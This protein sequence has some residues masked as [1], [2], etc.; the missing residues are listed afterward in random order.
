MALLS[1]L[2]QFAAPERIQKQLPAKSTHI[3]RTHTKIVFVLPTSTQFGNR[4][5]S[6]KVSFVLI[7]V[8]VCT[9]A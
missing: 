4:Q 1:D 2:T 5:H 7:K 8:P 6:V 3:A 9:K